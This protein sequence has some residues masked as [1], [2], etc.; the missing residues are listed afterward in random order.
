M[1]VRRLFPDLG[2]LHFHRDFRLIWL[3][4][5]VNNLGS[6]ITRVALPYQLYVLTHSV[7]ALGALATVQL[8]A[9]VIFALLGGAIADASDRRRL[10]FRTQAGLCAVSVCLAGLSF[11]GIVA[12]WHIFVLA[13][14][15][16][17]FSA[18]DRPA[19]QSMLPRLVDRPRLTAAIALNSMGQQTARIL[20]PGLGGVMI[21]SVG[22]PAAYALDALTFGAAI[23]A[24]VAIADIPPIDMTSRPNWG[25]MVEGIRFL[26]RTPILL[27]AFA[28]DLDAMV[29]GF[30]AGLF[31]VLAL[32]VFHVGPTG[33][34]MLTAARSVGAVLGVSTS[35]WVR[36]IRFQGRV[37]IGA[38]MVW[39]VAIALFGL[40]SYFPLA[41]LFLVLAGAADNISAIL[42]STIMQ[43]SAPDGL[44]G[45]VSALSLMVTNGGPRLGDMEGTGVAALTSAQVSVVSGGLLCI[46]GLGVV[47]WRLPQLISYDAWKAVAEPGPD[48][49][50]GPPSGEAA[51]ALS[52]PG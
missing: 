38:V 49:L 4:Q 22:L 31:P 8:A 33:L 25:A 34:G 52:P 36:G 51:M 46:L 13:L 16:G 41:L 20:G 35:G 18:V 50:P 45:R 43:L 48:S 14:I 26:A 27:S 32:D 42:R 9:L 24:L 15:S 12:P 2:P 40:T 3:G 10:L 47:L 7:V 39:G 28:I 30:P 1:K 44:R 29:F 37:V 11:S 6:E 21:A 23:A 5:L 17:I 19:R